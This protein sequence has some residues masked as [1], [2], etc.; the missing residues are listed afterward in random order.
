MS[1]AAETDGAD[2]DRDVATD[3]EVAL[4][5]VDPGDVPADA[6][7]RGR[8]VGAR[9][10]GCG[11]VR[12]KRAPPEKATFD[13]PPGGRESFKHVCHGQECRGVTWW[14]ILAVR[15]GESVE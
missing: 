14:N 10:V 15:G 12:L 2:D 4:E 13:V 8:L 1:R 7:Q 11:V 9:C 3:L 6:G 5:R